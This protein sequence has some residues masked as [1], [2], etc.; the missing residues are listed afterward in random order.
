[1]SAVGAASKC[2]FG[3]ASYIAC[4]VLLLFKL[5]GVLLLQLQEKLPKGSQTHFRSIITDEYLRVKGSNDSIYAIGDA[6]TIEQ[7]CKVPLMSVT[8]NK[9]RMSASSHVPCFLASCM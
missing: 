2:L 8:G 7:V 4:K 5:L 1:M 3:S 9:H 6:A